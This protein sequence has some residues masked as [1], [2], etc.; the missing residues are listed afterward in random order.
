MSKIEKLELG[1]EM[2]KLRVFVYSIANRWQE[3]SI[4]RNPTGQKKAEKELLGAV[5]HISPK[6]GEEARDLARKLQKEIESG[7]KPDIAIEDNCLKVMY[8][9]DNISYLFN[10]DTLKLELQKVRR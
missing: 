9:H 8:P 1:D 5:F 7:K 10:L 4:N 2:Y 3:S 6:M